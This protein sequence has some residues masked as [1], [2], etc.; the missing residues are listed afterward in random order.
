MVIFMSSTLSFSLIITLFLAL[1]MIAVSY[2]SGHFIKSLF[3]TLVSGT[4]ALFAVNLLTPYTGVGICLN[5]ISFFISGVF[6]IPGVIAML[7]MK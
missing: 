6:G 7:F 2:K 5:Y 4:G 3:L 1:I